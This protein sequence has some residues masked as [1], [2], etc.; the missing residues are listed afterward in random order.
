MIRQRLWRL[1]FRLYRAI[2]GRIHPRELYAFVDV[3]FVL[4]EDSAFDLEAEL[5][6]A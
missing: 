1:W 3:S 4:L 5:R 2:T 6:K